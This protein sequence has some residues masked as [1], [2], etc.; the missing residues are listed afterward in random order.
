MYA[1]RIF[2][3]FFSIITLICVFIF[4]KT[5]YPQLSVVFNTFNN[6]EEVSREQADDTNNIMQID[7]SQFCGTEEPAIMEYIVFDDIR[8]LQVII[9][10][11]RVSRQL[12]DKF[13][14]RVHMN[15]SDSVMS[16]D[17]TF[18]KDFYY[19]YIT[20]NVKSISGN[21]SFCVS[22]LKYLIND[23]GE[24]AV[25]CWEQLNNEYNGSQYDS[26][27]YSYLE[28]D[29]KHL[30]S[31][32]YIEQFANDDDLTYD[33]C[34]VITEESLEKNNIYFAYTFGD[35][36]NF[37]NKSLKYIKVDIGEKNE[38]SAEK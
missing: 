37:A 6:Q 8:R 23:N 13:K 24:M 14:E 2:T 33:A 26:S 12:D 35:V 21:I 30:L 32:G 18:L 27:Q 19:L 34:Y 7:E 11:V 10:D 16:E 1:K 15:F 36:C 5:Y 3:L 9:S 25:V 29:N 4:I 38:E 31:R 22:S 17:Y 28:T 20:V